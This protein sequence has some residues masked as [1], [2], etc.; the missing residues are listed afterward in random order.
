MMTASPPP[1]PRR[2]GGAVGTV[3]ADSVSV[4]VPVRGARPGGDHRHRGNAAAA[5]AVATPA[6]PW[7]WRLR[8]WVM[9]FPVA[10]VATAIPVYELRL[11]RKRDILDVFVNSGIGRYG[12]LALAVIIWALVTAVLVQL[13]AELGSRW[14][15]R[16]SL[17]EPARP[18]AVRS[19]TV[20]SGAP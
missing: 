19:P 4:T 1:P 8:V 13:L 17:R 20:R 14:A 12:R 15:A 6:L 10:F 16:R 11:V 2:P 5:A 7:Y 18:E 9:A 3:A